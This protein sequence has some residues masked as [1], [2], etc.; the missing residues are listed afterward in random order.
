[1]GRT[2]NNRIVN[3]PGGFNAMRLV[4]SM[5]D[6]R[7]THALPHSLRAELYSPEPALMACDEPSLRG[8]ETLSMRRAAR[9]D[10]RPLVS[11]GHRGARRWRR[12]SA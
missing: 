9:Y 1:M 2:E 10:Q 3:F 11:C 4:G 6:V 5:L 7:I 8:D 12:E